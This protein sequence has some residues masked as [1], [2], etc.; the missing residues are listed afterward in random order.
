VSEGVVRRAG[1]NHRQR[2]PIAAGVV[3]ILLVALAFRRTVAWLLLVFVYGFVV[4]SY[5][6]EWTGALPFVLNVVAFALLVSPP[7][8]RYVGL[9]ALR[10]PRFGRTRRT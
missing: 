7:M 10:A 5:V 8:R 2:A 9:G 6:W 3:A 4:I 1:P